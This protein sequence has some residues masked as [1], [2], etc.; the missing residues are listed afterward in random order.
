MCRRAVCLCIVTCTHLPSLVPACI[1]HL[2]SR[3]LTLTL[4]LTRRP[5]GCVP[6]LLRSWYLLNKNSQTFYTALPFPSLVNWEEITLR[7]VPAYSSAGCIDGD[8]R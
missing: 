7:L 3:S 6:L 1:A 4:A 5:A 2:L 8:A